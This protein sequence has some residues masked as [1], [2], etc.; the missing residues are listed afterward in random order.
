[1]LNLGRN[2]VRA[3]VFVAAAFAGA[4]SGL[5]A[6]IDSGL[7]GAWAMSASD[8]AHIF[9]KRNGVIGYRR[10]VDKFAQAAIIQPG[11]IL[12]PASECRIL[13]VAHLKDSLSLDVECK[14]SVSFTTQTV[15]IKVQSAT[16]IVYSPTSDHTLDTT[17]VKCPL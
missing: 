12:A 17:L 11:R 1:M 10:P 4:T 5:A 14:D 2:A 7:L 6:K 8:C 15:G 9:E 13:D 16:Q 3:L